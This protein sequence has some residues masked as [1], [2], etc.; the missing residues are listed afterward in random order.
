MYNSELNLIDIK[1][2]ENREGITFSYPMLSRE[3]LSYFKNSIYYNKIKEKVINFEIENYVQSNK[4][5]L[6]CCGII[7]L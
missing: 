1:E 7:K 6:E 2:K 3:E 4:K 5:K